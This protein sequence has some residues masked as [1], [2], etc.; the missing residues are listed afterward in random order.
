MFLHY[1][2][3]S[4]LRKEDTKEDGSK[5]VTTTISEDKRLAALVDVISMDI[6]VV[7]KGALVLQPD[8]SVTRSRTFQGTC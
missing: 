6:S 8:Q 2:Q 1:P 4:S 5:V 7:P 3:A